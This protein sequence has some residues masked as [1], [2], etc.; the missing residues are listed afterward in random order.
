MKVVA[1]D[2]GRVIFDFD[3]KLFLNGIKIDSEQLRQQIIDDLYWGQEALNYEKGLISGEEFFRYF[4]NK[5]SINISYEDFNN[6]WCNIFSPLPDTI[7]LVYRLFEQVPLY[8]IS[9]IN[10]EHFNFLWQNYQDIFNLFNDF[11]LSFQVKRVKPDPE[12]YHILSH[13][14]QR[15]FRDIIYI[16]DRQ[17]LIEAAAKLGIDSI[18]FQGVK[19]LEQELAQ[20]KILKELS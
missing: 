8:L 2:L 1:F 4:C 20:R 5:Y 13:K 6:N 14:T 9:N 3:Y 16:D 17:D 19:Y 7:S 11:V 18:L 12:I 10:Q 15:P